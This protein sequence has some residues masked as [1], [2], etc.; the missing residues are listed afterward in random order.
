[1]TSNPLKQ[2][3]YQKA[4]QKIKDL[5]IELL[6]LWFAYRDPRTPWYAKLWS[7]IV[8]GYAFS[9]IDLIPDF[10]PVLGYLDDSIIL[11]IG[12][13]I[14]IRLIPKDVLSDS[15]AKAR[16]WNNRRKPKNLIAAGLILSFW[17]VLLLVLFFILRALL[18]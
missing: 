12:I 2:S 14:A 18:T 7:A 6:A 3:R 11:P 9:P 13:V 8:A 16:E 5:R 10:I 1:M 15:R 4:K 17:I